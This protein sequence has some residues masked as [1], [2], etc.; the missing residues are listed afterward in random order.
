MARPVTLITGASAGLG[1]E[2][3]RQCARR[4]EALALAARRRDRLEALQGVLG[5]DVHVF[6]ADLAR[7]GAGTSLIEQLAAEGL[8]VGTLV[9]NA[10]FGLS[11][12]FEAQDPARLAEMIELNVRALTELCRAVLPGMRARGG[13]AILNVASTA[14]FQPGPNMA[15]YYATKAYVLSLTEALHEEMKGSN[16]RVTGL[17]PGPTETEFFDVAEV[18]G[19]TLRRLAGDAAS[20]V[21]QGLNGLD[22]G[23]AVVIPGGRN[24]VGAQVHRFIPRATMRRVMARLKVQ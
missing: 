22:R 12:R 16:I 4:G 9:N 8:E 6:E 11:G 1:A 5:G 19:G 10:G 13:G 2:F 17:C 3:A 23:K 24:K 21:R 14:A 20:V 15:V 7:P 18:K